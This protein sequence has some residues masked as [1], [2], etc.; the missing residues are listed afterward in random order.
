MKTPLH[1]HPFAGRCRLLL[2]WLT[3]WITAFGVLA[4]DAAPC[5]GIVQKIVQRDGTITYQLICEGECPDGGR[6]APRRSQNHHGGIRE[7]CG[8]GEQE[9]QH[10]HIVLYR[11]GPG[12]GGGE[13]RVFCAGT[14]PDG[15]RC[16][17]Q[18]V[19][20]QETDGHRVFHLRCLCPGENEPHPDDQSTPD[21][22]ND[23]D[24]EAPCCDD[25]KP[26]KG[27][28]QKVVQADG[29]VTFQLGCRGTCPDGRP[30]QTHRRE[31]HHGGIREWCGCEDTE[32][33]GCHIVLYRPGRGEGG[34]EPRVFCA[35]A[36]PDG[37]ACRIQETLVAQADGTKVFR[38]TCE[39]PDNEAAADLQTP[40]AKRQALARRLHESAS[41][42]LR[43]V[44]MPMRG[45]RHLCLEFTGIPET[46]YRVLVTSDFQ[47]WSTVGE[48]SLLENGR[49]QWIDEH[50]MDG[51]PRFYIVEEI[52]E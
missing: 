45:E 35:G 34:G 7:W 1:P 14:C 4:Q 31:N 33:R 26:C 25:A 50:W 40:N 3:L 23:D 27:Y 41:R 16:Q 2:G 49:F 21:P 28:V 48:A 47:E 12:E 44:A 30:C 8:C 24:D 42:D 19:L 29:T 43:V 13:H 6:C 22:T 11:P 20:I 17:L 36:C 15:H 46:R 39:C 51:T 18:E 10:C 5:H 32:P 52:D 37:R 9:P 38:Y